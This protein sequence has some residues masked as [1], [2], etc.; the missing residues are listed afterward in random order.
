MSY[1]GSTAHDHPTVQRVDYMF[2]IGT[3]LMTRH[4][5]LRLYKPLNP[6]PTGHILSSA[7]SSG[8][9]S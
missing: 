2:D 8:G 6:S 4:T 3:R 1:I 9:H 7:R 5:G